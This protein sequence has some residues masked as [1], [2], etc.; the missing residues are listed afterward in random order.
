MLVLLLTESS[1]IFSLWNKRETKT[2]DSNGCSGGNLPQSR[3]TNVYD[4]SAGNEQSLSL[5][6]IPRHLTKQVWS[7]LQDHGIFSYMQRGLF[8]VSR[9][10]YGHRVIGPCLHIKHRSVLTSC[11][12]TALDVLGW[13]SMLDRVRT[14]HCTAHT[15]KKEK[16]CPCKQTQPQLH[17]DV[18]MISIKKLFWSDVLMWD[19]HACWGRGRVKRKF[20]ER[21]LWV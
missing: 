15:H 14:T 6:G 8:E 12:N 19:T 17:P 7:W 9:Y 10:S 3:K 5:K 16:P 11:R 2:G 21:K 20:F 18:Q 4:A 1:Q 13:N